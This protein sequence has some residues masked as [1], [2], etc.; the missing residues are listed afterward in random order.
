MRNVDTA[1]LRFTIGALTFDYGSARLVGF[2]GGAPTNGALVEARGA[3]LTG[4]VLTATRLE[5]RTA[6]TPGSANDRG[7]VE[8]LITRFTSAADFE[9]DGQRVTTGASRRYQNGSAADLAADRRV[10]VE[11][12]FAS[13]ALAAEVVRFEVGTDLRVTAPIDSVDAAAGTIV[14]LG[15]TIETNARTIFVDDAAAPVRPFDVARLAA[16]D[17]VEVRGGPGSSANRSV[18]AFVERDDDDDDDVE[19]RG[20]AENLLQPQLTILDVTI[21]TNAATEFEDGEE[22]PRRV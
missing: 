19:L 21:L 6:A 14:V 5:G 20:P 11:G 10:E 2:A 12:S 9:F 8:G 3:S 1:A 17:Y 4:S 22:A 18:A 7:A 15:I 16:S 13:G